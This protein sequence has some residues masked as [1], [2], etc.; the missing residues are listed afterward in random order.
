MR[1]KD[2]TGLQKRISNALTTISRT[3]DRPSLKDTPPRPHLSKLGVRH[4]HRDYS[5]W[6]QA[7]W[8]RARTACSWVWKA[9]PVSVV[10][11][12]D[13]IGQGWVIWAN[14]NRDNSA[15]PAATP[16]PAYACQL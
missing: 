7:G 10:I 5:D 14:E 11:T 2:E 8:D 16:V 1:Q 4:T 12:C 3:I 9:L 13:A 15:D 6:Q